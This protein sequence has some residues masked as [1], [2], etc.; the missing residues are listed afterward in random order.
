MPQLRF[1]WE[2]QG[3]MVQGDMTTLS[4]DVVTRLNPAGHQEYTSCGLHILNSGA[5]LKWQ[6]VDGA[7]GSMSTPSWYVMAWEEGCDIGAIVGTV[8][9][10]DGKPVS[11]HMVYAS[12]GA[13]TESAET[14]DHG[15]Y[16]F[17]KLPTDTYDVFSILREGVT[18]TQTVT[19]DAAEI[20]IVNFSTCVELGVS[21]E[22]KAEAQWSGTQTHDGIDSAHLETTGTVHDGD[23]ARIRI[24]LPEG[25]TL[26][27]LDSISWWTYLVSGYVPHCDIVLDLDENG[28]RDAILTA[29]GAYQNGD[30][31]TGWTAATWFETFDGV[32]AAYPSWSG[33][34]GTPSLAFVDDSSAVWLSPSSFSPDQASIDYLSTYKSVSGKD[35]VTGDTSVLAIEIELDNWVVQTEAYVDD[36]EV[37][38]DIT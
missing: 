10:C 26:G 30:S 8:T 15:F 36:V 5:N 28:S 31:T 19:L 12:N 32:T 2:I 14:D 3:D 9:D 35:G 1:I 18:V 7:Q 37:D 16:Y 4:F 38:I 20:E 6:V 21:D 33:L 27:S 13:P 23:E 25:T 11:G 24:S 34:S 29:E 17:P 22:A